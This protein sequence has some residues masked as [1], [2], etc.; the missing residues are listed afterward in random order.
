MNEHQAGRVIELLE[1][2]YHQLRKLNEK[3]DNVD[4][5]ISSISSETNLL[6][7]HLREIVTSL[8]K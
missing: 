3:I 2:I 1:E 5:N 4:I 7:H 8:N 6:D